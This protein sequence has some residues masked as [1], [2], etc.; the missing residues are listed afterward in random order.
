M[1]IVDN[2]RKRGNI[3]LSESNKESMSIKE[4]NRLLSM[5]LKLNNNDMKSILKGLILNGDV[6]YKRNGKII[7]KKQHKWFRI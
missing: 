5:K 2:L 7:I 1:G 3:I 4:Y 6:E